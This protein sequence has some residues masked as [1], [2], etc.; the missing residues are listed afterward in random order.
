MYV[1]YMLL[2]LVMG[3]ANNYWPP[4]NKKTTSKP[5]TKAGS[6]DATQAHNLQ[7]AKLGRKGLSMGRTTRSRER[8]GRWDDIRV[9]TLTGF[10]LRPAMM[11]TAKNIEN[12]QGLGLKMDNR[13]VF[14]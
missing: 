9:A 14:T 7:G 3:A 11:D 2:S 10:I 5:Y 13:T 4:R 8:R 1:S 6:N 12:K